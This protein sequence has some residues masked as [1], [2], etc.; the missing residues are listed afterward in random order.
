MISDPAQIRRITDHFSF[1]SKDDGTFTR[2]FFQYVNLAHLKKDSP[3]CHEGMNCSHL[4]L[5][6][7]GS[8]RVYKLG[9]S[10][11]EITLY[12]VTSGQSCILTASCILNGTPFPA[13]AVAEEEM[14][15][16]I[17]PNRE[18]NL[19]MN[20]Y[21]VWRNYLFGLVGERL[22]EVI[23]IVEEIAFKRVDR[24][25]IA[26][27]LNRAEATNGALIKATHQEIAS[28]LGTSR[29]VVS[30]ILKDF[31]QRQLISLSRGNIE[32]LKIPELRAVSDSA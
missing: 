7:S 11:R 23:S 6:L 18:V 28:E 17:I 5:V 8:A 32:L 9:E 30:R 14:T 26:L 27:L 3:I 29:E 12:R 16:I 21:P 19:W 25:I 31:H 2:T 10:G 20:Q 1:F 24:R 13:F 4:A 15:G 22:S